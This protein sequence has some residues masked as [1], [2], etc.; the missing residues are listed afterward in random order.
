MAAK[1]PSNVAGAGAA[2][3]AIFTRAEKIRQIALWQEARSAMP[4][5]FVFHGALAVEPVKRGAYLG[6]VGPAQAA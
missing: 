2:C 3:M 6:Q 1:E 4:G 5:P